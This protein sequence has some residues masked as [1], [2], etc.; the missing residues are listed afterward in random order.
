[1][2]GL[3]SMGAVLRQGWDP[4]DD[5]ERRGGEA[6]VK[7]VFM[8]ASSN[9]GGGVGWEGVGEGS[10]GLA[11]HNSWKMYALSPG[12]EGDSIFLIVLLLAA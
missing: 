12:L 10:L 11:P 7:S 2:G 9:K 8:F 6:S 4:M 1:M 5:W 3:G